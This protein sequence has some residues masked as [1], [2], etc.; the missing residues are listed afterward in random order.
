MGIK[1]E[2]KLAG[3]YLKHGCYMDEIPSPFGESIYVIKHFFGFE[4]YLDD[5]K[6]VIIFGVYQGIIKYMN[7]NVAELVEACCQNKLNEFIHN[8]YS[9]RSSGYYRQFCEM[10]IIIEKERLHR[11]FGSQTK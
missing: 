1:N 9:K 3:E 6:K 4:N 8:K 10:N 11:P 7:V 5:K 2:V